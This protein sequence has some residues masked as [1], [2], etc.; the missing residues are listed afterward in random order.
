[1]ANH[2]I[3]IHFWCVNKKGYLP[4]I[5]HYFTIQSNSDKGKMEA[6]SQTHHLKGFWII[7]LIINNHYCLQ[8]YISLVTPTQSSSFS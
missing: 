7:I 2:L 3:K 6:E 5:K 8:Q 1:M 4:Q